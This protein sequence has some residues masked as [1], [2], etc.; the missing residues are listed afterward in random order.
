MNIAMLPLLFVALLVFGGVFGFLTL[1]ERRVAGLE[2]ATAD[3]EAH[4]A[5]PRVESTR[6]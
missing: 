5:A 4:D 3:A 1:L 6:A 2:R